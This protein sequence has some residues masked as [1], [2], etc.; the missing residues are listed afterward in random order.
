LVVGNDVRGS[1]RAGLSATAARL[2][3][4]DFWQIH[5]GN[6]INVNLIRASYRDELGR[7]TL[8]MVDGPEKFLV[9]RSHEHLVVR[10]RH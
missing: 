2:N 9:S 1:I 4:D 7:L 10:S 5:R 8:T 3:S 6:V